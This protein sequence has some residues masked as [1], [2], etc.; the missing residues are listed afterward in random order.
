MS[1][2]QIKKLNHF[3]GGFSRRYLLTQDKIVQ[4]SRPSYTQQHNST[5]HT[6]TSI[7]F[8]EEGGG[9]AGKGVKLKKN[10]LKFVASVDMDF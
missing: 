2:T 5:T 9:S 1:A 7:L 4:R 10:F 6:P 8:F 3:F